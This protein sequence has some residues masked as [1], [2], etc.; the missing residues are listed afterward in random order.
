MFLFFDS[1]IFYVYFV[2]SFQNLNVEYRS[3]MADS[4]LQNTAPTHETQSAVQGPA[5]KMSSRRQSL[6]A[7]ST[8]SRDS[9]RAIRSSPRTPVQPIV[10]SASGK[11][12]HVTPRKRILRSASVPAIDSPPETR[13]FQRLAISTPNSASKKSISLPIEQTSLRYGQ[14]FDED[15]S[16]RATNSPTKEKYFE[17]AKVAKTSL[18]KTKF[19]SSLSSLSMIAEDC[20]KTISNVSFDTVKPA[21]V[22]RFVNSDGTY[23]SERIATRTLS[24]NLPTIVKYLYYLLP[25]G[26]Y[27]R[28]AT[29]FVY[30]FVC[31]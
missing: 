5:N 25:E 2:D 7:L 21:S 3:W 29:R 4:I 17:I 30:L 13:K 6:A 22:G 19:S 26:R 15:S 1:D 16:H 12:S 27:V 18:E 9:R 31:L 28:C 20:P 8:S 14:K 10:S 11:T 23:R 24:T